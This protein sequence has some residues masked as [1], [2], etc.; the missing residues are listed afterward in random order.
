MEKKAGIVNRFSDTMPRGWF[1]LMFSEELKSEEI[2]RVNYFDQELIVF[3]TASGTAQVSEPYCPHL[4][5]HLGYNGKVDGEIIKCPFHGWE[6][7]KTGFC[8]RIP[9]G[10]KIPPKAKLM[11]WP[12]I[13]SNGQILCY[14]DHLKNDPATSPP[15]R[16]L[17]N[18]ETWT[19]LHHLSWIV[20]APLNEIIEGGVDAPHLSF[21]HSAIDYPK[22]TLEIEGE[23]IIANTSANYSISPD[24]KKGVTVKTEMQ[25][26]GPGFVRTVISS[27]K[28]TAIS[29]SFL[30]PINYNTTEVQIFLT[31]KKNINSII[32][33]HIWKSYLQNFILDFERD[34]LV[35]ETKIFLETP[36]LCDGDGPIMAFRKWLKQ[37]YSS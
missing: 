6:F 11:Y 26:C 27:D 36:K 14:H 35:W 9:Y 5:G 22:C 17:L 2:K 37:F 1:R 16:L 29:E 20:K 18:T 23:K 28:I 15:E 31:I 24:D 32:T 13:E 4:G 25:S 12:T 34:K 33:E 7:D 10:N 3:R 30:T 21:I 19:P 8:S